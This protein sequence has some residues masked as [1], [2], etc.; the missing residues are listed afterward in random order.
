MRTVPIPKAIRPERSELCADV[1]KPG[2]D[3][4]EEKCRS[5]GPNETQAN[6]ANINVTIATPSTYCVT[7][8]N[9]GALSGR[10]PSASTPPEIAY[11]LMIAIPARMN[12][13]PVAMISH[14]GTSG[15]AWAGN[16]PSPARTG[17]DPHSMKKMPNTMAPRGVSFV[18]DCD[19]SLDDGSWRRQILSRRTGSAFYI[20]WFV[21]LRGKPCLGINSGV[22]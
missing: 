11:P 14:R 5:P 20:V 4:D 13:L 12:M 15:A 3:I 22:G 21:E 2:I 16:T 9:S 8:T 1:E 19:T 18:L 10:L 17:N 6:T 7:R